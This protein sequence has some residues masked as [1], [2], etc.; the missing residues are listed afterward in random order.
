MAWMRFVVHSFV[1]SSWFWRVLV[2]H[3]LFF[4]HCES[5]N[6]SKALP[7][8]V[9]HCFLLGFWVSIE[10]WDYWPSYCSSNITISSLY[11]TWAATSAA[12]PHLDVWA[13]ISLSHP[14]IHL[15]KSPPGILNIIEDASYPCESLPFPSS[16]PRLRSFYI[17]R[18][19]NVDLLTSLRYI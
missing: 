13:A 3:F 2:L 16:I 6:V 4:S 10:A 9:R 18:N 1:R 7:Q 14:N 15:P 19:T 5:L 12:P 17:A 8:A 11:K